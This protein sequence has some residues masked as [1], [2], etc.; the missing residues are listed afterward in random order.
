MSLTTTS[1][2][3]S[4]GRRHPIARLVTGLGEALDRVAQTPA[5]SMAPQEQRNALVELAVL[6]A[7][8]VELRMRV[9]A[10]GDGAAIGT[11]SG[12]SSTGA[13]VAHTTRVTRPAAQA[14]VR[15]AAA[16]N[17]PFEA[18]R[19]ALAAGGVNAEQAR[20]VVQAV[21]ALP[22]TTAEGER[23]RAELHLI[24]AA[25]EHDA[26][27]LRVLGRRVFE[28]IDPDAAEAEEGR[29]LAA[30]ER[31]AARRTYLKLFDSGDGT[32][33]GRFRISVLHAAMLTKM[34]HAIAS[35]KRTRGA[36]EDQRS[37]AAAARPAHP[38]RMGA[39]FGELIERFPADRLPRA[40]G[41]S[42]TVVAT[43][44]VERLVSGIGAVGLDTGH[45]ISAG[46]ARRLACEAGIIPAVLG[47]A[48]QVLDLGR[49]RRFH[50]EPQ[51]VAMG[52]R[53]GGCTAEG[54]DRPPGWCHAHHETPWSQGGGT[55]IEKGRLLCSW[56]HTRAHDPAYDMTRLSDGRVRFHRRT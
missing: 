36:D 43:T 27:E 14:E 15:L 20:V 38:D 6:E 11:V 42:A 37:G 21:E 19:V 31:D 51:R 7:R 5:W 56:H 25:Q 1:G 33:V 18:T 54:C 23:R 44:T 40:G 13:W 29:R 46:Q 47:G 10:A 17:G 34:L 16:L 24:A 41:I 26:K 28:V 45:Q 55:S 3:S 2:G 32:V 52:V 30:E 48:S 22:V 12:A 8:L 50:T 53:D 49:R 35:P 4:T 39:A 9:L